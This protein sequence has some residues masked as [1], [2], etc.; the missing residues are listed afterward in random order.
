MDPIIRG[1]LE[2]S[3]DSQLTEES[4]Q[5]NFKLYKTFKDENLIDSIESAMISQIYTKLVLFYFMMENVNE[6]SVTDDMELVQ[7]FF[8][9]SQ[10]IKTRIREVCNL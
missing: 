6:I 8:S 9:R 5:I 1:V 4:L 3:L 10:I 7:M 2:Q